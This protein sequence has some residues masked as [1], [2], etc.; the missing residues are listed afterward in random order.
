MILKS[1]NKIF[2]NAIVLT[3]GIATG[4]STVAKYLVEF[5]FDIIDADKISHKVLDKNYQKIS[6]LFG[7]EYVNNRK[8]DRKKLGVLI[9]NNK[10]K[11][12]ELENLL[13]PLIK[14][15][16]I[17]ISKELEKLNKIY[18]I[19]IPLFFEKQSYDIKKSIV[20]YTTPS[21]QL[22]RLINRD[23]CDKNI[24]QLKIN[25]QLNIEKKRDLA[26]YVINNTKD[27]VYLENEIKKLIK[28]LK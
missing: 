12:L 19:D 14:E 11:K 25:N 20:V 10:S 21:I 26:T 8:V 3:G 27:I 2:Q 5:G 18:F 9:F 17:N 24:A 4:K 15:E 22:K 7:K 13:H 1:S 28:D 6:K 16:I 23:K